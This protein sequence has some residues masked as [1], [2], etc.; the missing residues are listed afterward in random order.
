MNDSNLDKNLWL[1][2]SN[3][4]TIKLW[5]EERKKR[6]KQKDLVVKIEITSEQVL[7]IVMSSSSLKK[8]VWRLANVPLE[9]ALFIVLTRTLRFIKFGSEFELVILGIIQ[10]EICYV[11]SDRCSWPSTCIFREMSLQIASSAVFL[12]KR[13]FTE[14]GFVW[15]T[16]WTR[17]SA[18][19]SV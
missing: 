4:W 7:S 17:S 8:Q 18:W 16:R 6:S 9:S 12:I 1:W 19:N 14:T 2:A 5:N 10:L 3:K 13:Y 11:W 15:P